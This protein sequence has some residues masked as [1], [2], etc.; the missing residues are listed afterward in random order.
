MKTRALF[1]CL[2]VFAFYCLDAMGAAQATDPSV[3]QVITIAENYGHNAVNIVV[4]GDGM[5]TDADKA[6]L[7]ALAT[8]WYAAITDDRFLPGYKD[9]INMYVLWVPSVDEGISITGLPNPVTWVG[10]DPVCSKNTVYGAYS[11]QV[12]DVQIG[13]Q[14]TAWL[15]AVVP[16]RSEIVYV[17]N[18]DLNNM[19]TVSAGYA[20]L[21]QGIVVLDSNTGRALDASSYPRSGTTDGLFI[22][23][24]GHALANLADEYSIQQFY[25]APNA[26]SAATAGVPST[27]SALPWGVWISS[28]AVQLDTFNGWDGSGYIYTPTERDSYDPG[29][30]RASNINPPL[31]GAFLKNSEGTSNW[32]KPYRF[33]LWNVSGQGIGD[34]WWYD[35]GSVHLEAYIVGLH[36][37]TGGLVNTSPANSAT[38]T[39]TTVFR[40]SLRNNPTLSIGWTLDGV[41]VAP[42]ADGSVTVDPATLSPG[43]HYVKV[44]AV[45]TTPKVR[46][47]YIANMTDS[48][49]WSIHASSSS[50]SSSSGGVSGSSSGG[51]GGGG[52]TSDFFI[53]GL[54]AIFGI[55]SLAFP[56]GKLS[57]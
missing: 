4:T 27:K 11:D 7:V 18:T 57:R 28:T 56:K 29:V 51:G 47:A 37:K 2:A 15:N 45:D 17:C 3:Y 35:V 52:A 43:T 20:Y 16:W 8:S 13:N 21:G 31:I 12:A 30:L 25:S 24:T 54:V 44:T 6:K 53:A 36:A 50:S 14:R 19:I 49:Q 1:S 46:A 5:N 23:E 40:A 39:T 9:M 32:Y 48:V 33:S 41:N 26:V 55:R 38:L 22:H 34:P 10:A 42:A